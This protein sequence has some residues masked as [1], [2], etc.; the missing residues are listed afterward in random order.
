MF[1]AEILTTQIERDSDKCEGNS[2]HF[3]IT[4]IF[5]AIITTAIIT[6]IT[7]AVIMRLYFE[8]KSRRKNTIKSSFPSNYSETTENEFFTEC[9]LSVY[10][11]EHTCLE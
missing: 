2:Y 3:L 8:V 1:L 5:P 11:K 6:A 7:T 4:G 10:S 9:S